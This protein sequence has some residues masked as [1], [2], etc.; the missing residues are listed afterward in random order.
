ML[1]PTLF[2]LLMIESC[3]AFLPTGSIY[4]LNGLKQKSDC[5]KSSV[6]RKIS[7]SERDNQV[8]QS[9]NSRLF[10]RKELLLGGALITSTSILDASAD[11][12][13]FDLQGKIAVL[14]N[15]HFGSHN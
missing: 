12:G 2:S 11:T 8:I 5:C 13:A 10:S 4:V 3:A 6:V 15:C 14:Q 9:V 1:K 7:M